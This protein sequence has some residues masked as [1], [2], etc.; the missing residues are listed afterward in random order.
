MYNLHIGPLWTTI[1]PLEPGANRMHPLIT[2]LT[3]VLT[4]QPTGDGSFICLL[5]AAGDRVWRFPTGL[6]DRVEPTLAS[7]GFQF[8]RTESR[9]QIIRGQFDT[10]TFPIRSYQASA[11]MSLLKANRP[12]G[13]LQ[14]ATG[15]GKT[16]M[17]AKLIQT[18]RVRTLFVVH[19][20]DLMRQAQQAFRN[21]LGIEAG[22]IGDGKDNILPV[23]VATIQTLAK[24]RHDEYLK[25]VDMVIF[26]ECHHVAAPTLY[27]VRM[28]MADC[29][30]VV[31]L[32]AS[33]WRDDGHDL[34]IEA[35]C[36]PV[37]YRVTASNLIEQGY[38]VAPDIHI[39]RRQ[40]AP[41]L[42]IRKAQTQMGYAKAYRDIV[43][44]D[45]ARLR[46]VAKLAKE[47]LAL[48]RRLL[49][50][51]KYIE[52]GENLTALIPGSVF[53]EGTNS[54]EARSN[55]F[56][57][58]RD[59]AI[60]CLIG[61]SL[62]DEG[63]DIP[64]ADALILAGAGASSTRALQRIGRVIRPAPG[65]TTAYVADIVDEHPVFK[66]QFY[67]RN[68]IYNTEALFRSQTV[69]VPLDQQ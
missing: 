43:V 26:D 55:A 30:L 68:K 4:Y 39:Y 57:A 58:F 41:E 31:G 67:A 49:V 53:V 46:F 38:L 59:G 63:V 1:G 7:T 21:F 51:V 60:Q 69:Q 64:A 8:N 34:L 33:P 24:G 62:C 23:T 48:G 40:I 32:S 10:K 19:T 5:A 28:K 14:A 18:T 50:L 35:A 36:G 44:S 15:A 61:T 45:P 16:A 11:V 17:A 12:G 13:I 9:R 27:T 47:Q 29:P 56:A 2:A 6:L 65:K 37:R 25:Q 66:R 20:K 42:R 22:Q 3:N 54:A 52:H